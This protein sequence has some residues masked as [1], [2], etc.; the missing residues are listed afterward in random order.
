MIDRQLRSRGVKRDRFRHAAELTGEMTDSVMFYT[1]D[2]GA[3]LVRCGACLALAIVEVTSLS[4]KGQRIGEVVV[5]D[6]GRTNTG[7]VITGQVLEVRINMLQRTPTARGTPDSEEPGSVDADWLWVGGFLQVK[8]RDRAAQG[9]ATSGSSADRATQ[10]SQFSIRFPGWSFFP[11]SPDVIT[12]DEDSPL[13]FGAHKPPVTWRFKDTNLKDL[14]SDLWANASAFS[15]VPSEVIEELAA[16]EGDEMFP[17]KGHD[18][19][20]TVTHSL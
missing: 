5:D 17:Y 9:S 13:D 18:G 4:I 3:G 11:L 15:E 2:I 19:K 16:V 20:N 6:L 14:A 1:G 10:S 7:L 8:D 12:V